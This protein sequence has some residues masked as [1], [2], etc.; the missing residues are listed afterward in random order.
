MFSMLSPSWKELHYFCLFFRVTS[1][2]WA[3]VFFPSSPSLSKQDFSAVARKKKSKQSAGP[4]FLLLEIKWPLRLH[5]VLNWT[6][7]TKWQTRNYATVSCDRRS[8]AGN[9]FRFACRN[10][11]NKWQN[12]SA[13]QPKFVVRGLN[14]GPLW[15]RAPS[16]IMGYG[17]RLIRIGS[18]HMASKAHNG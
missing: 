12:S 11:L 14:F 10:R 15:Q 17:V 9:L 1:K 18:S 3:R 7:L 4:A 6:S 8:G 2:S 5:V 16:P 13:C